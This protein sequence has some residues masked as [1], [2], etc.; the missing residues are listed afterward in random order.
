MRSFYSALHGEDGSKCMS[1]TTQSS[2]QFGIREIHLFADAKVRLRMM[3]AIQL[4]VAC[5]AMMFASAGQANAGLVL[6]LDA[7]T[8]GLTNGQNVASWGPATASGT[9]TFLTGQTPNGKAAVSFNG[10][11]H[12]GQLGA[13]LFPA[14]SS[15]DFIIAA[16][17]RANDISAYHNIIDDNNSN[18]PMLWVHPSFSYELNFNGGSKPAAGGGLNGWDVVIANSKTAQLWVNSPVSN[19][20]GG[21]PTA[22]NADEAFD[23]FNRDGGKTFQGMVAELRVYNDADEFGND[24]AGLYNELN[25]KWVSNSVPEPTSLAIFGIGALGMV[26]TR[27]R[28]KRA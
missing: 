3:R 28:R 27:R 6:Q 16:V 21:I 24:Y 7:S 8:L 12:F 10:S 4:A 20:T 14:S 1:E 17:L 23:L 2:R 22:Y 9:P 11:D 25:A 26:G 19:G 15:G 18:K 5:V 13:S